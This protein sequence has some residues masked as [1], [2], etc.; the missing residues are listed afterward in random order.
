MSLGEKDIIVIDGG[1]IAAWFETAIGLWAMEGRK[2][3]GIVSPGPW[4]Q[5]GTGPAYATAAKMAY[6]KSKV[7]LVT[8]DGSLGLAP[9]LTP[10][11]TSI[12]HNAPITILVANNAQWGMIQEQQKA[13]WGTVCAT[14]L[15]D[16]NYAAIF[17]GGGAH[18]ATITSPSDLGPAI[19]TALKKNQSVS[20]LLDVKTAGIKSPLTQGLVDMRVKTSI[21]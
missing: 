9:G 6:P 17:E 21:E 15:R 18:A 10:L 20:A 2:I 4:E 3:K 14:S 7:I 5:M 1:D 8:G 13:M 16:V 19:Q 12:D 11:E